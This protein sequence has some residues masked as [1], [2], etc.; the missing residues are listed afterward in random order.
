MTRSEGTGRT[1]RGRGRLRRLTL[2]PVTD[3]ATCLQN[4]RLEREAI[5]LYDRLAAIEKD[6]GRAAAFRRIAAN[7]QA[8]WRRPSTTDRPA[9][10]S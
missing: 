2:V 10:A 4:L 3:P 1:A 7:G 9:R 8:K 5:W 6:R